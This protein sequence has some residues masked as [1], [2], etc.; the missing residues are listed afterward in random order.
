MAFRRE[1]IEQCQVEV[2]GSAVLV[3]Y[4]MFGNHSALHGTNVSNGEY[5]A[6]AEWKPNGCIEVAFADGNG[7][8]QIRMYS[9]LN[10]WRDLDWR[11]I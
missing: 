2:E 3:Y 5:I 11:K 8:A 4:D 7:H 6:W 10:E 9:D 1:F